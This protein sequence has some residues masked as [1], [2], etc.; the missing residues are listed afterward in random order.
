MPQA[1]GQRMFA[2]LAVLFPRARSCDRTRGARSNVIQDRAREY[3]HDRARH[4]RPAHRARR[5][6]GYATKP[7]NDREAAPGGAALREYWHTYRRRLFR[8]RRRRRVDLA[9]APRGERDR[10]ADARARRSA[11]ATRFLDRQ[12]V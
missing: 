6:A 12:L 9:W 10:A 8:D 5:I 1:R 7:R 3:I 4:L 11:R 2:I